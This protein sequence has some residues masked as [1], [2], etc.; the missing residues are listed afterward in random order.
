MQPAG[1]PPFLLYGMYATFSS[2]LPSAWNS[3]KTEI[4]VVEADAFVDHTKISPWQ[5]D[6]RNELN[7]AIALVSLGRETAAV[8]QVK[9]ASE[10]GA[11]GVIFINTD[12][13]R[14]GLFKL[15][16]LHPND[17]YES[18]IPVLMIKSSDAVRLRERGSALIQS[19][20]FCCLVGR[21][22]HA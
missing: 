17:D 6:K 5:L 22:C 4:G 21:F 7:G 12:P 2:A 1:E 13:Q 11:V 8:E 19:K 9:R 10:G 18:E 15:S 16:A 14:P 3:S 20:P